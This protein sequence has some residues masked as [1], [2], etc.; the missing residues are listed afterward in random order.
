MAKVISAMAMEKPRPSLALTT[1]RREPYLKLRQACI[2]LSFQRVRWGKDRAGS[3]C[4]AS[5]CSAPLLVVHVNR[6]AEIDM[7]EH[8]V[9]IVFDTSRAAQ[10]PTPF[11]HGWPINARIPHEADSKSGEGE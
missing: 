2:S 4:C 8:W 10:P 1:A 11:E 9:K 5:E 3:A 7:G 6:G